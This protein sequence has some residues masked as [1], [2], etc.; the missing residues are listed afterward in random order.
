M[1]MRKLTGVALVAALALAT[2]ACGE[3]KLDTGNKSADNTYEVVSDPSF[4]AGST[5]EK[6]NKAGSIKI[7]VKA[8]QPG[9]GFKNPTSGDYEGIDIE[10]AKIVAGQ[11]GLKPDQITFTETISKN[12]EPFLQAGTV[13][14]V[15]ASYSITDKRKALV[16]FAGPYYLTGQDLMVRSEDKDK[17]KGPDDL[18][19]KK[20]CSVTAST[21]LAN[22]EQK[23]KEAQP[24]GLGT[25][26]EC[27]EQLENKTVDVVTTDGSILLGYA[28]RNP[29]KLHVVGKPFSEERYG[30]GLKKDDNDFRNFLNDTLEKAYKNGDWK[31]AYDATLGKSGAAAPEP[32]A[33]DRY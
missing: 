25:Y 11:L 7:G 1:R 4:A 3:S 14:L 9:I 24:V 6:L 26:S 28:A 19:G 30:I 10:M 18:A 8:D 13:D 23:Y 33:V 21:P 22:I 5:M 27:V 29:E 2:A 20:V 31:K 16:G 15:I 12:R 32:P 17:I